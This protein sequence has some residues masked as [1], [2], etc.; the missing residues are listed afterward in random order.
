MSEQNAE[1]SGESEPSDQSEPVPEPR[2]VDPAEYDVI[3]K[4]GDKE[5]YETRDVEPDEDK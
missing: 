4:G 2:K 5:G 3:E 1:S